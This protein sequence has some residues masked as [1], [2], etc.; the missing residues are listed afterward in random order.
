MTRNVCLLIDLCAESRSCSTLR[1]NLQL[2]I[3]YLHTFS[4]A[5]KNK[6]LPLN[7][8]LSDFI[9]A[10]SARCKK[11]YDEGRRSFSIDGDGNSSPLFIGADKNSKHNKSAWSKVKGIVT[12]RSPRKTMKSASSLNSRDVSPIDM[13]IIDDRNDSISSSNQPSPSHNVNE[14]DLIGTISGYSHNQGSSGDDNDFRYNNFD[15]RQQQK[16]NWVQKKMPIVSRKVRLVPEIESLPE[17]IPLESK[18][19][20]KF[21]P[22]P[23]NLKVNSLAPQNVFLSNFVVLK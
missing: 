21:I 19:R 7:T 9:A 5:L 4:R 22:N 2:N 12:N 1:F 23:L 10:I 6:T 20:R 8:T 16:P 11:I 17:G 15:R 14:I 3:Q 13:M 18:P